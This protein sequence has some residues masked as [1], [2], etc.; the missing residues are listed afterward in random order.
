MST[1]QKWRLLDSTPRLCA[2]GNK[3]KRLFSFRPESWTAHPPVHAKHIHTGPHPAFNYLSWEQTEPQQNPWVPADFL[4]KNP[5]LLFSHNCLQHTSVSRL[6]PYLLL[7][8]Q[9]ILKTVTTTNWEM[10]QSLQSMFVWLER[11]LTPSLEPEGKDLLLSQIRIIWGIRMWTFLALPTAGRSSPS[12]SSDDTESLGHQGTPAG[13]FLKNYLGSLSDSPTS[14]FCALGQVNAPL[15]Q[16][17]HLKN[18]N[19]KLK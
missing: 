15:G 12:H 8:V 18:R 13:G 19:N 1:S 2:G 4:Q 5:E 7:S 17:A 9:S 6:G 11:K 3:M 14:F 10:L 16:C